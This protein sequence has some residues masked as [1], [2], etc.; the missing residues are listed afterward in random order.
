MAR[1]DRLKSGKEIAQLGACIGR[2]FDHR[3]IAAIAAE[4]HPDFEGALD[5]LIEAGL[6]Y[7]HGQRPEAKY[8]FKHAL[9]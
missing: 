9:V 3:L 8:S 6:L 1:L 2:D 5:R 4:N 7:R